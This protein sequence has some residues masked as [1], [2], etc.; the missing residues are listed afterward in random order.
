MRLDL[1]RFYDEAVS[2][3]ASSR[4]P[5]PPSLPA[6]RGAGGTPPD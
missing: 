3:A 2:E 4:P 6:A 5:V 1:D